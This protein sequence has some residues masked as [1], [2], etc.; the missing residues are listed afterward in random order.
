MFNTGTVVG[1]SANIFGG[2]FP[3]KYIP[4][5]SWGGAAS[6]VT[7]DVAKS[8]ETA[9]RVLERRNMTLSEA[10]EQLFHYIFRITQGERRK[11]GYSD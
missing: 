3:P 4:S 7:Y 9:R 11:R 1:Y 10:E 8:I 2:E 6:F 5:F